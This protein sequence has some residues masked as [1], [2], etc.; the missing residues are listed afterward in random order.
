MTSAGRVTRRA[1]SLTSM[2]LR[3]R[4]SRAAISPLLEACCSSSYQRF[5]SSPALGM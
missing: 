1:V 2:G 5:C 3:D 4:H